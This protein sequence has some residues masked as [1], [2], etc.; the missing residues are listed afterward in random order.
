MAE[1]FVR[2][3][4]NSKKVVKINTSLQQYVPKGEEGELVW[5]LEVGTTH[6]DKNGKK[7]PPQI[8][9]NVKFENVDK[10]INKAISNICKL[11][12]WDV[13]EEDKYPPYISY[14]YP[15]GDNVPITSKVV[16]NIADKF[17]TSGID[18]SDMKVIFNNGEVDF[19]ITSECTIKG[20]PYDYTVEWIPPRI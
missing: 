15:T 2:N 1:L 9:H 19:D 6:L 10:E 8:I 5:V 11:I 3:S 12:D 14:Y 7:I 17:P 20:D 4:L 13:L 16:F 18:L